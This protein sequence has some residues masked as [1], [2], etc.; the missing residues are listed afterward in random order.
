MS[1]PNLLSFSS[2]VGIYRNKRMRDLKKL[3][4][5]S[6]PVKIEFCKVATMLFQMVMAYAAE[7]QIDGDFEDYTTDD[8]SEIFALNDFPVLPEQA[9]A[10]AKGFE[11]V[12][13]IEN[14]KLRSWMKYNRHLGD[15]EGMVKSKRKAAK[16]MHQR[17][18][19]EARAALQNGENSNGKAVQEHPKNGSKTDS[20]SKQL[21]LLEK[22]LESAKGDA[23]KELLRKKRVLLSGELGVDL[24]AP[25]ATP[26]PALRTGKR[27]PQNFSKAM[28]NSARVLIEDGQLDLL[29]ES[30]VKALHAAGDTIPEEVRVRFPKLMAQLEEG[31]NPVRG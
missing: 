16:L 15:Y 13:L 17:R 10:I 24:S 9:A 25:A 5:K 22:A 31:Q 1:K 4:R 21:W 3:L 14:Q 11:E 23:R 30:M 26:A 27:Q 28:L 19:R 8:W 18:E 12:G 6:V 7:N 20:A 29:N 2:S